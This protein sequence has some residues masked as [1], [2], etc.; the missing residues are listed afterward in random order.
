M[1][2]NKHRFARI[3]YEDMTPEYEKKRYIFLQVSESYEACFGTID[4]AELAEMTP[5]G[6]MLTSF[7][8]EVSMMFGI[9]PPV[10]GEEPIW[11]TVDRIYQMESGNIA[12]AD[13]LLD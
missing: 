11:Q 6:E 3:P 13:D 4:E 8:K 7:Y 2:E 1:A 12:T 9:E 10:T 5:T